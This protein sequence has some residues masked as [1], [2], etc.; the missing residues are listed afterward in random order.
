MSEKIKDFD[1]NYKMVDDG[2]GVLKAIKCDLNDPDSIENKRLA[3][4]QGDVKVGV[5]FSPETL[6][7]LQKGQDN[8]EHY[9]QLDDVFSHLKAKVLE[10]AVQLGVD[11][12]ESRVQSMEDVAQYSGLLKSIAEKDSRRGSKGASG[13]VPLQNQSNKS[14]GYS[15]EGFE[16]HQQM[17]ESLQRG[18]KS[19]NKAEAKECQQILNELFRKKLPKAVSKQA[20]TVTIPS[21]E[22]IQSGK[23]MKEILNEEYRLRR[24]Q[25]RDSE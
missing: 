23:G 24:K 21:D 15:S 3:Q 12:D 9:K 17:I 16:S 6:K 19:S 2:S 14:S 20:I 8:A 10:K 4:K 1:K 5:E 7:V 11:L 18:A 22:E 13:N 25:G